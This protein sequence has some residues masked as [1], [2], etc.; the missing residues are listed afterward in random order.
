MYL[1]IRGT[2][3]SHGEH[4]AQV[5][6]ALGFRPLQFAHLWYRSGSIQS[7]AAHALPQH[8]SMEMVSTKRGVV[9]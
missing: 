5:C 4:A 3:D 1:E 6:H 2:D 7:V 9:A 8:V